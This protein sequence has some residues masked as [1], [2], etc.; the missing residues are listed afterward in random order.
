MLLLALTACGPSIEKDASYG[1]VDALGKAVSSVLDIECGTGA[2]NS[3]SA[4]WDQDTC[5]DRA[6]IGVF[7]ND[8]TQR[9]VKAKN[10]T[11]AGSTIVEGENWIVWVKDNKADLVQ[12][13]L[14]GK[15]VAAPTRFAGKVE[16]QLTVRDLRDL[17][18]PLKG[19]KRE[20][21][22]N[23]TSLLKDMGADSVAT[24][25][26]SSGLALEGTMVSSTLQDKTCTMHY[27]IPGIPAG[28]GPYNVKVGYRDGGDQTEA[29]LKA[30]AGFSFGK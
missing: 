15:V 20:C 23:R 9:E 22:A 4:G 17:E 12:E 18:R 26:T 7:T 8:T 27:E 28:D 6:T 3:T 5:G 30:G 10:P 24:I 19:S 11:D 16:M 2:G 1:T 21:F 29:E 14:G 13:K 25:T